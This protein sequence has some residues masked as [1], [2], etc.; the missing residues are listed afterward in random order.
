MQINVTLSIAKGDIIHQPNTF[1]ETL[2]AYS[3]PLISIS[4]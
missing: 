2:T 1:P 4:R 3:V